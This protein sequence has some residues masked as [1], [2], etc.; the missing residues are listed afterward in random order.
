V[1]DLELDCGGM[2]KKNKIICQFT[3]SNG[4]SKINTYVKKS[5]IITKV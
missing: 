4:F 2:R 5:P 1:D 3:V